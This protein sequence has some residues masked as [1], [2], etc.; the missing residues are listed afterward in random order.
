MINGNPMNVSQ[1]DFDQ[2]FAE[3]KT[4]Y[5]EAELPPFLESTAHSL[6]TWPPPENLR[7]AVLK[8]F[9]LYLAALDPSLLKTNY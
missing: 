5:G 9:L 3:A 6:G 1:Y 4:K 8:A 2:C 7:P